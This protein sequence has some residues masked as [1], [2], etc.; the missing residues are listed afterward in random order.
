MTRGENLTLRS[1]A[2]NRK[3]EVQKGDGTTMSL[4]GACVMIPP[5][6]TEALK[7]VDRYKRATPT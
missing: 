3:W 1:N 7:K 4:P 2:D 6:D 5:P